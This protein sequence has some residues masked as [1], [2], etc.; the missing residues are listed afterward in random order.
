[1]GFYE[2]YDVVIVG[3]GLAGLTS[4]AYLSRAGKKVLVCEKEAKAGGLVGS[5]STNGFVFDSGIRAFENSG[6]ILPMLRDLGI[7]L[8]LV[9][10]PVSIGIGNNLIRYKKKESLA[11]YEL[12]L[13]RQ[14]PQNKG[15]IQAIIK[16][17][18]KVIKYMDVLYGIDNPLFVDYKKDK[19]YLFQTLLP[20]LVKYQ[21]NI[22]KALKINQPV[23]DYLLNFTKNQQLIDMITQHFFKETP[24]FFALSYFGLY[25]DYTYPTGGTGVLVDKMLDFITAHGGVF[26]LLARLSNWTRLKKKSLA[27]TGPTTTG[28]SFG[29]L[30]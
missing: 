12:L 27:R 7:D 6:I 9:T 24:A 2:K 19:K 26:G 25:L 18:K 20:W 10:S 28:R 3:G 17:I 8:D 22:K 14:F 29:R 21:I 16:E 15:D 4:A 23:N 1:M 30:I 11:Q 5:F 13:I